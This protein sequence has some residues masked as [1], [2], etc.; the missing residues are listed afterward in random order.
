M[1]SCAHVCARVARGCAGGARVKGP[2]V[3]Y[4]GGSEWYGP[5]GELVPVCIMRAWRARYGRVCGPVWGVYAHG[6]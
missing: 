6:L 5:N 2:V 3:G 1:T 4:H